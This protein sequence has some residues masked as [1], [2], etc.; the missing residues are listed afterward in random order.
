MA[1][2]TNTMMQ[3]T[4]A[5]SEDTGYQIEKSIRFNPAAIASLKRTPSS[6]GNR[7]IFTFAA[8]VKKSKTCHE[9]FSA[10]GSSDA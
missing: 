3:G 2:L 1:V 8:W 5:I 7:R 9:I 6:D 10:P 4:A